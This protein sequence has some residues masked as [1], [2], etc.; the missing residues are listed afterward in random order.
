MT[1]KLALTPEQA[2]ET[3]TRDDD[4]IIIAYDAAYA[5]E[6]WVA[7]GEESYK[8]LKALANDKWIYLKDLAKS[9]GLTPRQLREGVM[10]GERFPRTAGAFDKMCRRLGFEPS[11]AGEKLGGIYGEQARANFL[12]ARWAALAKLQRMDDVYRRIKTPTDRAI[13]DAAINA[14]W[15]QLNLL[16]DRKG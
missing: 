13:A 14:L 2:E 6:I 9:I 11:E 8:N 1:S 12:D 7:L 16:A 5:A 3:W 15:T 4:G 10:A